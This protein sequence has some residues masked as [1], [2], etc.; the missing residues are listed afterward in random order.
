MNKVKIG[1]DTKSNISVWYY[2]LA[3]TLIKIDDYEGSE[4]Y[5]DKGLKIIETEQNDKMNAF[6]LLAKAQIQTK[7]ADF[8]NALANIDIAENNFTRNGITVRIADCNYYRSKV[9]IEKKDYKKATE[10]ILKSASSYEKNGLKQELKDC[11]SILSEIKAKQKNYEEALFYT[12]KYNE[13]NDLIFSENK[14]NAIS[15]AE[16]KYETYLKELQ[17]KNQQLQ[18]QKEKANKNKALTGIAFILLFG[19]GIILFY[20]YKQKQR[21]LKTQNTLLGLQQN[22]MEAELSN[23]N[24]QLD[25]H[26]IKNLLASIA[27]EIQEKA[28]ESY[29]KMLKLF[30]LT[31]ASLNSNSITDTIENQLQQIDDFLSLEKSMFSI[32]FEYTIQNNI[33]NTQ[34]QIPR[35]LLKNLVENAI[36]HG[37]KQQENGGTINVKIEQKDNF[38]YI[39]VDDTGI[40]RKQAISLDSGI[41]TT[42]Y[43]KLFATLNPKNKE[44]ATFE[45]IDKQQGTKVEVQIPINYKYN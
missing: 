25:P 23:L 9:Y 31:K 13:T 41:G 19:L 24:K 4:F 2:N 26:E 34:T 32:P 11:Y 33:D 18:I 17:L 20:R 3:N 27:P 7:E 45:I 5:I 16:I 35:L 37:I 6:F 1:D 15:N 14:I 38:I 29:K 8:E 30:N 42:T 36:K 22:L 21:N 28:P 40:G 10:Y 43:Q 44:N 12:K 39:S